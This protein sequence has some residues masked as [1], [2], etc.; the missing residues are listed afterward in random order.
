MVRGFG[1]FEA[2]AD[3]FFSGMSAVVERSRPRAKYSFFAPVITI[4]EYRVAKIALTLNRVENV[5]AIGTILNAMSRFSLHIL[6]LW[7]CLVFSSYSS[8]L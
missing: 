2:V 7:F 3:W 4:P 5:I 6:H 8:P 1:Y